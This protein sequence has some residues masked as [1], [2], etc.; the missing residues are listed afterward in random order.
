MIFITTLTIVLV[1]GFALKS[2]PHDLCDGDGNSSGLSFLM[3][4]GFQKSTSQEKCTSAISAT[5]MIC[6]IWLSGIV[7]LVSCVA[8][9]I[10]YIKKLSDSGLSKHN[11]DTSEDFDVID[12]RREQL[13]VEHGLLSCGG[14]ESR[15]SS[16]DLH[17]ESWEPVEML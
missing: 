2:M 14:R 7:F 10:W 3:E 17:S 9:L 6:V 4:H 8:I 16:V 11:G 5:I 13:E 12:S 15:V 1:T